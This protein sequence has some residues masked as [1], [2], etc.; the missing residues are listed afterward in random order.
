MLRRPDG[1]TPEIRARPAEGAGR[2]GPAHRR[3]PGGAGS[4]RR[5]DRILG[6]PGHHRRARRRRAGGAGAGQLRR[7]GGRHLDAGHGRP[8]AAGGDAQGP[9]GRSRSSCCRPTATPASCMR[10][11]HDGAF[12]YV[13]KDDGLEPLASA[14][15]RA[16]DH[17]RLRRENRRLLEEQRQMNLLLEQKVRERTARAGRGEPAAVG[18]ARRAGPGGGGPAG[19]PGPADPGGEDGHRRSVHRRHRPRDQQPARL[20]AARL[21]GAGA[22]GVGVPG[23][24]RSRRW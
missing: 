24:R 9:A 12:D 20:P 13:N 18:R 8:G 3:Q 16:M 4:G 10:A 11:V 23:R 5:A 17:V 15:Q 6:P 21:R 22:L 19:C 14:V 2:P 7:G 1:Q